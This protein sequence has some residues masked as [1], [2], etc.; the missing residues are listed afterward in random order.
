MGGDSPNNML[1][2][3]LPRAALS[4]AAMVSTSCAFVKCSEG[5]NSGA[6]QVSM[7]VSNLLVKNENNKR[8]YDDTFVKT[9]CNVPVCSQTAGRSQCARVRY[10]ARRVNGLYGMKRHGNAPGTDYFLMS[11]ALASA[12]CGGRESASWLILEDRR[13]SEIRHHLWHTRCE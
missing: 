13:C 11:C 3:T 10:C 1:H 4:N 8:F 2:L 6:R 12:L 5:Q 9:H 7:V